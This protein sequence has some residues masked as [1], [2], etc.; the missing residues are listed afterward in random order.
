MK[1]YLS[2]FMLMIQNNFRKIL[3]V[4]LSSFLLQLGLYSFRIKAFSGDIS[5]AIALD[6]SITSC[7]ASWVFA[8]CCIVIFAL[9]AKMGCEFSSKSGYTLKRLAVEEKGVFFIEAVYNFMV[10]CIYFVINLICALLMV[11]IYTVS[12]PDFVTTQSTFI[13]FYRSSYL[14]SLLPLSD[15]LRL[16]S[17]IIELTAL[18]ILLSGF[19]VK[20]RRGKISIGAIFY[21]L[22]CILNF[23]REM[24]SIAMDV[25]IILLGL[26]FIC[27]TIFDVMSKEESNV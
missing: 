20:Q 22:F 27:K 21:S 13:A 8:I 2:V 15:I 18:A 14:H 11:K 16:S 25:I 7:R 12:F 26:Y 6:N 4:M 1:K 24:G 23:V 19:G 5:E 17:N 3:V 9:L 10:L